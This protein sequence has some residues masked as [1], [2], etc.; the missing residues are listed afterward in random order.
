MKFKLIVK[1]L[2]GTVVIGAATISLMNALQKKCDV[3]STQHMK[4]IN[5]NAINLLNS[6]EKNIED[7]V[8]NNNIKES[9]GIVI[10]ARHEE[11]SEIIKEALS[12][13]NNTENQSNDSAFE[14]MTNNLETLSK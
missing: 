10:A 7:Q 2:T 4:N 8:E 13:V 1:F 11:A 12:N 9:V 3:N 5:S 6:E 14:E